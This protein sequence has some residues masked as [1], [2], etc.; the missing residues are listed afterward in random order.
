MNANE[1]CCSIFLGHLLK[2]GTSLLLDNISHSYKCCFSSLMVCSIFPCHRI[3]PAIERPGIGPKALL[4][5]AHE[6]AGVGKISGILETTAKPLSEHNGCRKIKRHEVPHS[7]IQP[8]HPLPHLPPLLDG[9]YQ[10]P[11]VYV[12]GRR[13]HVVYSLLCFI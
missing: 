11:L 2:L 8:G 3:G 5:E 9:A 4:A 13:T 12:I 10:C 7:G 6:D 1:P